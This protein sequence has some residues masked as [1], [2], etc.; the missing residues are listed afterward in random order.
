MMNYAS[1]STYLLTISPHFKGQAISLSAHSESLW[2]ACSLLCSFSPHSQSISAI[3]HTWTWFPWSMRL[4]VSRQRSHV[5]SVEV[6]LSTCLS[7]ASSGNFSE[8]ALHSPSFVLST[9]NAKWFLQK[10]RTGCRHNWQSTGP[11][12]SCIIFFTQHPQNVCPQGVAIC[13]SIIGL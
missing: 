7:A 2:T 6:Q 13:A 3:G 10:V 9:F 8:Q 1:Y 12:A 5:T 11:L 4:N